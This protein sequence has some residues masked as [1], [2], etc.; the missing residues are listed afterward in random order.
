MIY[1][2][3]LSDDSKH[4]INPKN[5]IF[6][7]GKPFPWRNEENAI[8]FLTLY[9]EKGYNVKLKC[10][11]K[12]EFDTVFEKKKKPELVIENV[13][14]QKLAPDLEYLDDCEIERIHK[15]CKHC[16]NFC[17]LS[18]KVTLFNCPLYHPV[19]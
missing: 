4:I 10:L 14:S 12:N 2:I 3:S 7:K 9:T 8:K 13:I 18:T 15:T 5:Y 11:P 16:M 17:K 6:G 1:F 19:S